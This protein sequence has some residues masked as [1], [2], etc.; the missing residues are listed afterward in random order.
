MTLRHFSNH[1]I[2]VVDMPNTRC[3]WN[4]MRRAKCANLDVLFA[5]VHLPPKVGSGLVFADGVV[6]MTPSKFVMRPPWDSERSA[7]SD[8]TPL[9]QKNNRE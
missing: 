8:F 1:C 2:L 7:S 6:R 5:A 4:Q 3:D 9:K